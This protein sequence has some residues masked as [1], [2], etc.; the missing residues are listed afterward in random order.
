MSVFNPELRE[1]RESFFEAKKF[2][3]DFEKRLLTA[4]DQKRESFPDIIL[5]P[6]RSCGCPVKVQFLSD[7]VQV[8]C[9]RCGWEQIL[10]KNQEG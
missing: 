8:S 1:E 3:A 10:K 9:F 2:S 7:R 6:N 5:C 4:L